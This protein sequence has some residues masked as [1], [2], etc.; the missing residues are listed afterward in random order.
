MKP[1]EKEIRKIECQR[2]GEVIKLT[3][4]ELISVEFFRHNSVGEDMEF[5]ISNDS[6]LKH[7]GTET[8]YIH[9]EKMKYP[10]WTGGDAEK[11]LWFFEVLGTGKTTLTISKI[12]RG[13]LES[14]C[15]IK[16]VVD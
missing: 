8:E 9:P 15:D 6:I 11:G 14:K 1:D 4:N 5:A 13:T 16:I 3:K 12:L 10:E 2:D 7:L